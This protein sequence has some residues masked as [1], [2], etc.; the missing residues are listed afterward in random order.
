MYALEYLG[1]PVP[2]ME[3]GRKAHGRLG[4]MVIVRPFPIEFLPFS[5]NIT[6]GNA[7]S[8]VYLL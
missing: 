3:R 6:R 1:R 5:K 4:S 8:T 2:E 7:G